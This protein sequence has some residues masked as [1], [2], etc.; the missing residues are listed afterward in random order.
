MLRHGR[1]AASYVCSDD[2]ESKVYIV[3]SRWLNVCHT[4]LETFG[5]RLTLDD[6]VVEDVTTHEGA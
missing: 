5:E 2:E 6:V 4:R 1:E 3:E